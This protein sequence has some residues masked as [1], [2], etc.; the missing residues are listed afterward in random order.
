[1]S[2]VKFTKEQ[3]RAIELRGKD[4]LVYA[5]AGSGKTTVLIQ[6]IITSILNGVPLDSM[7]IV[8]F[9]R[10]AASEMRDRLRQALSSELTRNDLDFEKQEFLRSQVVNL[11]NADIET[12]DAFCQKVIKAYFNV[13]GIDPEFRIMTDQNEIEELKAEPFDETFGEFLT[14]KGEE[15]FALVKNFTDGKSIK[16]FQDLVKDLESYSSSLSDQNSWL[17]DLNRL[18][19]IDESF[20]DGVFFKHQFKSFI[21]N[22]IEFYLEKF[23]AIAVQAG[24]IPELEFYLEEAQN[25]IEYFLNIKDSLDKLNYADLKT[26]LFAFDFVRAKPIRSEDEAIIEAKNIVKGYRDQIKKAQ[27]E[28]KKMFQFDEDELTVLTKQ[29]AKRIELLSSFTK[30]YLEKV[31][32]VKKRENSY[33]FSDLEKFTNQ[34]LKESEAARTSYQRRFKEILIDEYQDINN[35]QDAILTT[36]SGNQRNLFMVGDIKQSIYGFRHANPRLFLNKYKNFQDKKCPDQEVIVIA[37]NYRSVSN[38]DDT[39]NFF[40]EQLMDHRVGEIDYDENSHLKFGAKYFPDKLDSQVEL[41]IDSGENKQMSQSAAQAQ[42][43]VQRIQEMLSNHELIYDVHEKSLREIKLSD[44]AILT[45]TK[46]E[47]RIIIDAFSQAGINITSG[48]NEDFF[49]TSEIQ[50]IV[51]FLKVIDNPDQDIPLV[52]VL[53]SPFG[54][55]SDNDLAT[56]RSKF[57]DVTFWKAINNYVLQYDDDISKQLNRL[58]DLINKSR[59]LAQ[60][61]NLV[62]LLQFLYHDQ[63]FFDYV[64]LMIGGSYRE[65]NLRTFLAQAK[66]FQEQGTRGMGEFIRYLERVESSKVRP[67]IP[68]EENEKQDAVRLMT[69]HASKGL[70]FPVVFLYRINHQFNLQDFSGTYVLNEREGIGLKLIDDKNILYYLPQIEFIKQKEKEKQISEEMRIL[71]VA[72]TRAKQKLIM[73][74]T[75]SKFLDDIRIGFSK[76]ELILPADEREKANSFLKL[77]K[78]G[79]KGQVISLGK[80]SELSVPKNKRNHAKIKIIKKEVSTITPTEKVV[81]F[82]DLNDL[83][84]STDETIVDEI[85][86]VFSWKYAESGAASQAAYQSVSELNTLFNEPEDDDLYRAKLPPT[87]FPERLKEFEVPVFKGAKKVSPAEIGSA[88]H[89]LLKEVPLSSMPDEMTLK[90]VIE[91]LIDKK[92]IKP[93]VGKKIKLDPIINFFHTDL[94]TMIVNHYKEFER[95]KSFQAIA[96]P[97]VLSPNDSFASSDAVLIH[98]IIDG[99]LNLPDKIILLDY[100]T[101]NFTSRNVGWIAKILTERYRGQISV[102][103]SVLSSMYNKPV[104]KNLIA[105]ATG[106]VIELG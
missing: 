76:D 17:S 89:L 72:M 16:R 29:T 93:E 31:D 26:Q 9:T 28:L 45:R 19:R 85:N 50:I 100:K 53:K 21:Q 37:E 61:C 80:E 70:E 34:I 60:S 58:L 12:I 46:G 92:L 74:G 102:Y 82:V 104:E 33:E 30:R 57:V 5:S 14:D 79:L 41:I 101:D 40:F 73:V 55:L 99:F 81:Q 95:E 90:K 56:I 35:L 32:Q 27:L 97:N 91:R 7:L 98:G 65:H 25:G 63:H 75:D 62:A 96:D 43:L 38:I 88:T 103:S 106:N 39:V 52:A 48:Q 42:I 86:Q 59:Q 11:S 66:S 51:A 105:L 54:G 18:Y 84:T 24:L 87:K 83:I 47:N 10:A 22:R 69:M 77:F 44:I 67:S 94:G 23:K 3:K 13:V 71:Y 49:V 68:D 1:M 36:L 15:F 6:R 78:I 4:I 8:T 20:S 64:T 2:S